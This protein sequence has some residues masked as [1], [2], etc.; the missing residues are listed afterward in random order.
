MI[1]TWEIIDITYYSGNKLSYEE[2]IILS[3]DTSKL[4][5][6]LFCWNISCSHYL[7]DDITRLLMVC[8]PGWCLCY[9]PIP[10]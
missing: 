7:G 5:T 9:D 1:E 6:Y 4:F 3:P 2:V 10:A 8:L